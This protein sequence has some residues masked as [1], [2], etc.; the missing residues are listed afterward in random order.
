MSDMLR[1][2]EFAPARL[3]EHQARVRP[4][5]SVVVTHEQR[6]RQQYRTTQPPDRSRVSVWKHEMGRD[7]QLRFEA[8]AGDVLREFGFAGTDEASWQCLATSSRCILRHRF[9]TMK[10]RGR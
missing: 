4:D 6:L 3:R 5:G 1:Y 9:V 7:E 8:I 2:H 10:T